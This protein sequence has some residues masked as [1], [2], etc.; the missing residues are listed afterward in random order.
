[1]KNYSL[2]ITLVVCSAFGLMTSPSYAQKRTLTEAQLN[3]I[4]RPGLVQCQANTNRI[5]AA[6]II[7]TS[8]AREFPTARVA[9]TLHGIWVGRI[10]GDNKDLGVDYFWIIDIKKNEGLIIALR[11]GKQSVAIPKEAANAP[12]LT[13]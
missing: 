9:K 5:D 13:F 12:K 2:L 10:I 3:A 11:N 6:Y 8:N 1:M 7:P 4:V